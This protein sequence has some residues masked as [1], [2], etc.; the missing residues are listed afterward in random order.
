MS[1]TPWLWVIFTV[2]AAGSQ[3]LRNAMQKELTATLGT[4][5][6]T[7]V[8]FLFGL[9]FAIVFL[10]MVIGVSGEPFHWP[11]GEAL[12]WTVVGGLGQIA[13]TALML[14]AMRLRSF[15]VATAL[16]KIEP[17]WVAVFGLVFLGDALTAGTGVAILVATCGVMV[18]SWPKQAVAG[19][20]GWSWQP[21]L[22]GMAS[23]AL[24]GVAAIGYRGGILALDHP[25]FVVG[26]SSILVTGLV[27]QTIVLSAY[28]LIRDRDNLRAIF[29][30]WR[31][32]L[33]AGFMGAFASQFW[34]LA[35]A[36]E[37][38]ARVRTLA[39][40]EILFAQI[41]TRNLFRQK[42]ASREALGIGLIVAGVILLLNLQPA[43]P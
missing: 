40:V 10:G 30:A 32:S 35:F 15:V 43:R 19:D 9:P 18:M 27:F 3:T 28:L 36:V 38:A 26:A 17:L 13:A 42:L 29:Q 34:F 8:R 21:A 14:A 25:N 24:F 23:G 12:A 16:T 2:V 1:V 31:P 33:F 37:S 11:G 41:V 5:G 22:L 20:A 4:V 7:H 6:A 39:L